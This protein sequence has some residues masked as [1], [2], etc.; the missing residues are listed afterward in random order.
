MRL[1]TPAQKSATP[2]DYYVYTWWVQSYS[3]GVKL[4]VG[5]RFRGLRMSDSTLHT[6]SVPKVGTEWISED[7]G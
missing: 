3:D 2:A 5:H 1:S 6:L 4:E 7:D